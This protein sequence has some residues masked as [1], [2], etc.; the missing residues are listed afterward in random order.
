MKNL[1]EKK[2][3]TTDTLLSSYRK[4]LEKV[5]DDSENGVV[6][7]SHLE[8]IEELFGAEQMRNKNDWHKRG[9]FPPV[10][11]VCE[12]KLSDCHW[13][14]VEITAVAKHGLCFVRLGTSDEKYVP[15]SSSKFRP[16]QTERERWIEMAADIVIDAQPYAEPWPDVLARVYD[17]GLAK[18]PGGE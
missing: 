13:Y 1:E 11:T 7:K 17:A 16:L 12:Y 4:A 6:P 5:L 15:S 8:D 9:E 2:V 3:D 14:A 10:G 18:M